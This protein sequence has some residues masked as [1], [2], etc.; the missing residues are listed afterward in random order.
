MVRTFAV[1]LLAGFLGSV[2]FGQ[3]STAVTTVAAVDLDRYQGDWFEVARLPNRFQRKCVGEVTASYARRADGRLDVTNRCRTGDGAIAAHGVARVV[4]PATSARLKVRFAPAVL[5]LLPMVWGD[6]WIIGLA[7]DYAWAVVG[8]PDR[9]YLWI[10][11][12]TAVLDAASFDAAMAIAREQGF[13]VDAL[14]RT[15][16]AKLRN[17]GRPAAPM[18]ARAKAR[19]SLTGTPMSTTH[20]AFARAPHVAP[21]IVC[22]AVTTTGIITT[23]G[24]T[25]SG[26]AAG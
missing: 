16:Q 24:T 5:S 1:T 20:P 2:V 13:A 4:D 12:R 21:A 10:L 19:G 17:S 7:D 25:T 26:A 6:Y 18:I 9:D 11:S 15:P 14:V 8:S 3:G 23:T 22:A